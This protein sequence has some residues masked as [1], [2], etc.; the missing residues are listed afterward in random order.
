M[1]M[2][3]THFSCKVISIGCRFTEDVICSG[4]DI[5]VYSFG[6]SWNPITKKYVMSGLQ[7]KFFNVKASVVETN[8]V[9]LLDNLVVNTVGKGVAFT[10]NTPASGMTR[11]VLDWY[12][13]GT[14]TPVAGGTWSSGPTGLVGNYTRIGRV[15]YYTFGIVTGS[16]ASAGMP[17]IPSTNSAS[18]VGTDTN[19]TDMGI[20][21]HYANGNLYL[22][23]N[24]FSTTTVFSWFIVL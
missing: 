3:S 18:G 21:T 9:V 1:T 19:I 14:W 4:D 11:Q 5:E 20:A 13:E 6:D 23:S 10:A 24:S 22:T 16:K 2:W 7:P 8:N 15:V 17:H 12:E